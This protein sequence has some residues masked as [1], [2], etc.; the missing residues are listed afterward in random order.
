M[1]E[2]SSISKYRGK[3]HEPYR[4][5]YQVR[6]HSS[7]DQWNNPSTIMDQISYEKAENNSGKQME[8]E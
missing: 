5:I 3:E 1:H 4:F 6:N 7:N 2:N 8:E